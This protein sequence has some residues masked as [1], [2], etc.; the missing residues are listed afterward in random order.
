MSL[1]VGDHCICQPFSMNTHKTP[2][3]DGATFTPPFIHSA[4]PVFWRPCLWRCKVSS[5][6]RDT[7]KHIED[8]KNRRIANGAEQGFKYPHTL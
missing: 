3:A 2:S 4:I 7:L 6:H 8:L 5:I 1:K